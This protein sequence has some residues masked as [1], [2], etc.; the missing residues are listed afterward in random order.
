MSRS[1]RKPA[2]YT[3]SG[4]TPSKGKKRTSRAIR[5]TVKQVLHTYE[6]DFDFSHPMDKNRGNAG[7][8]S[9]DYGWNDF[10]DGRRNPYRV[11]NTLTE[12]EKSS[13]WFQQLCW[14]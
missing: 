1:K 3:A 5:R 9:P 12:E 6:E 13:K 2:H 8:R 10:G 14:K 7:S 11:E 4:A